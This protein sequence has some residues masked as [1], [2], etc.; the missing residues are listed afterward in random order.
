MN[1][2]RFC[3]TP[4]PFPR[5]AFDPTCCESTDEILRAYAVLFWF[6]LYLR[7]PEFPTADGMFPRHP[8]VRQAYLQVHARV[9]SHWA[10]AANR[11]G[12]TTAQFRE[13]CV[14]VRASW[15]GP[16]DPLRACRSRASVLSDYPQLDLD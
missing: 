6:N 9:F 8:V 13:V 1:Q 3:T 7:C 16:D 5:V 12:V 2:A 14:N 4:C 10:A 11:I 15:L